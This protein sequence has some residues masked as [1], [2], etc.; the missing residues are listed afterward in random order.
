MK[1]TGDEEQSE[2]K[3]DKEQVQVRNEWKDKEYVC[4]FARLLKA[5]VPK[6]GATGIGGIFFATCLCVSFFLSFKVEWEHSKSAELQ[7][8]NNLQ[9]RFPDLPTHA[10]CYWYLSQSE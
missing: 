10:V 8:A 6:L 7:K 1:L 9:H 5:S 4:F 2:H 3:L